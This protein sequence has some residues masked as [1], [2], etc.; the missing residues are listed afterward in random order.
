MW[1]NPQVPANLVTFTE[2]ILYG[3]LHF[4]CSAYAG[5][6]KL[7][8]ME[9]FLKNSWR[10]WAVNCFH[11]YVSS[12]MFDRVLNTHVVV[13]RMRRYHISFAWPHPVKYMSK[14]DCF[15]WLWWYSIIQSVILS[16][17]VTAKLYMLPASILYIFNCF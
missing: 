4:L 17:F 10:L 11:K 12:Y 2:E 5:S 3:K 9:L 8:M 6:R 15:Q 1:P 16:Y 14:P 13:H 7:S